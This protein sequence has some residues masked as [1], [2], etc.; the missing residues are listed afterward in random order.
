M[1]LGGLPGCAVSGGITYVT[2]EI[3]A[4]PLFWLVMLV[5]SQVAWVVAFARMSTRKVSTAGWAAQ[6]LAALVIALASMYGLGLQNSEMRTPEIARILVALGAFLGAVL[7]PHRITLIVQSGLLA[8]VLLQIFAGTALDIASSVGL[9][10]IFVTHVLLCI[11]ICWGCYGDA[12]QAVPAW[13]RLPEFWLCVQAGSLACGFA[14]QVLPPLLVPPSWGLIEYPL[15]LV[16]CL[17]V[18][19]WRGP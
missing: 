1:L 4:I 9:F 7:L 5:F 13:D 18:R 2:M 10:S 3:S 14:Y 6:I 11:V 8:L 12:V 17:L 15:V 16:A 19:V